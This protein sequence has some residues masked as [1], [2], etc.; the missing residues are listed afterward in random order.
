MGTSARGS[1]P[2]RAPLALPVLLLLGAGLGYG[3][4]F[5]LNKVATV[6]GIPFLAFVFWQ[7]LGAGLILLI[8]AFFRGRP[9]RMTWPHLKAYAVTGLMAM[10]IPVSIF[11]YV[12][13]KVPSGA[14]GLSL[15]LIP[16]L[17]YLFAIAMALERFDWRR[18]AGILLGLIGVLLV[19]LP[20]ASLPD[21][22][23]AGWILLGYS[24]AIFFA[25]SNI[26][27]ARLWPKDS[28]AVALAAGFF[29][30]VTVMLLPGR[31]AGG[32]WW[33]FDHGLDAAAGALIGVTLVMACFRFAFYEII[34]VSGPVF[35]ST[36]NY[37]AVLAGVGW[38]MLFFG[39]RHSPWIW[40]ALVLMM[41]GVFLVSRGQRS[42]A[43]GWPGPRA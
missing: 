26:T 15:T 8:V 21:R 36:F 17:T 33:F 5:A 24:T 25:A 38:G 14:L 43:G 35:F 34:R 11:A 30:A 27:G 10:A 40:A 9:P 19:L 29:F 23:M 6:G 39:E 32:Q 13:P 4:I 31:L 1:T 16:I 42:A 20:E 7:S 37:I 2:R 41:G 12:A 3:L 28:D 18:I 22:A